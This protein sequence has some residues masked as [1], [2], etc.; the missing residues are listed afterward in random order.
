L[1]ALRNGRFF[2]TTGEVLIPDFAVGG[3]TSGETLALPESGQPALRLALEWTLP[4]AFAEVV[5]GD[6]STVYRER[7]DLSDTRAF[8]KKVVE[9]RPD[10]KGRKWVRVEAWDVAANAAFTEPVWL[11]S[12]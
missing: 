11:E 12:R 4:M 10:L 9:L 8:G 3:K 2:V 6:G 7:V 5:S 1:D